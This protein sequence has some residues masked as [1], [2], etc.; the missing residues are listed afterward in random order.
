M[1]NTKKVLG[2]GLGALIKKTKAGD[3]VA[4]K[5][6]SLPL[7]RIIPNKYQPRKIFKDESLAELANSIKE[8]GL[9]HPIV[10][11]FNPVTENYE[12]IAGERRLRACKLA[13]LK[14]IDAIVRENAKEEHKLAVSLVENIQREDLN[15]IDTA[16]AIRQLVDHFGIKQTDVAKY[17]GKSKSA[18]SNILRLLDLDDYIRNG[19]QKGLISEGHGRILLTISN[20]NRRK[21]LF[22]DIVCKKL[23]VRK[24]EYLAGDFRKPHKSKKSADISAYEDKLMQS[25]STKVELKPSGKHGYGKLVIHYHSLDELDK[26]AVKLL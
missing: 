23:T 6:V 20:K 5:V 24:L 11:N 3:A 8:H 10:V 14:Y 13:G 16:L 15:P 21:R 17:C 18:V 25:L 9:T 19:L 7:N 26:I 4:K 12:L 22:E 2:R 1:K